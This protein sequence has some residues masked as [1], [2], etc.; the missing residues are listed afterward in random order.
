MSTSS[1]PARGYNRSETSRGSSGSQTVHEY[2]LSQILYGLGDWIYSLAIVI[3]AY[4]LSEGLTAAAAVLLFQASGRLAGV[5]IASSL[6]SSDRGRQRRLA[7]GAGILRATLIG[8]LLLVTSE[9]HLWLAMIVAAAIGVLGPAEENSRRALAPHGMRPRRS[10]SLRSRFV[11]RWDQLAMVAGS[12]TGGLLIMLW[13]EHAALVVAASMSVAAV[14]L[15]SRL[16]NP[17]KSPS[18]GAIAVEQSARPAAPRRLGT[19]QLLMLALAGGA[20]LGIAIRILLVEVVIG[21]HGSSELV[22]ALFVALAGAGAF[23]GPISVPRLLGKLPSEIAIAGITGALTIALIATHVAD[24]LPLV[25]PIVI[26]C[27]IL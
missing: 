10:G 20:A 11:C 19:L 7:V 9:S 15:L 14:A 26:G 2:L 18:P 5:P 1:A 13:S 8:T 25:V 17:S 21:D 3:L 22:Y 23:A 27:G 12:V 6:S 16:P 4:R 24:R